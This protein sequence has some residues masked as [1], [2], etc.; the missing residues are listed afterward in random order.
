MTESDSLYY[1]SAILLI[2]DA[3]ANSSTIKAG[4]DI[5]AEAVVYTPH[6]IHAE[7]L[8]PLRAATPAIKT[9]ALLH[10]LHDVQI[11]FT[12]QLNL[13]AHNAL[14]A[15]R[16]VEAQYWVGTHDEV[17]TAGG[18]LAPF[19]RRKMWTLE[20]A[21]EKERAQIQNDDNGGVGKVTQTFKDVTFANLASG[22]SLLL[23]G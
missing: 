11:N 3:D 4:D 21:L 14:K 12:K 22:E 8:Q 19:L 15:Q 7:D 9:V 17:K 23:E 20:E 16:I 1:H 5:P 6:G 18:I 13:G 10:G 2:F